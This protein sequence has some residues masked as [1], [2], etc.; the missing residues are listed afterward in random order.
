MICDHDSLDVKSNMAGCLESLGRRDDVRNAQCD[1]PSYDS[2]HPVSRV[3]TI[4]HWHRD[5]VDVTRK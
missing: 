1:K 5:A 4:I 3:F 2:I